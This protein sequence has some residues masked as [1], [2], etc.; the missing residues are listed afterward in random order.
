MITIKVK[1][2]LIISGIKPL[3]YVLRKLGMEFKQRY[4]DISIPSF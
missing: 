4:P 1:F 3:Y 2:T